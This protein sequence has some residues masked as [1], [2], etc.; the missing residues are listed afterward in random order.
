MTNVNREYRNFALEVQF[1]NDDFTEHTKASHRKWIINQVL[2]ECAHELHHLTKASKKFV[3]GSKRLEI[4]E[5]WSQSPAQYDS[6]Q[7]IIEGQ[8]VM[9]DWEHPV[10]K[11]MAD[12]VTETHGD[13]LEIG[14]GMGISATYIQERGVKSHTIVEFNND[15]IEAF[16]AWKEQYPDRDIKL[17]QG[18]WP[19]VEDQVQ[20]YDGIFFD[21]YP[22]SEEELKSLLIAS[23]IEDFYVGATHLKEGGIFTFYTGEIDSLSRFT[24]RFLLKIFSSLTISIVDSLC[25]PEDCHYYIADSMVVVKAIK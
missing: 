18:K 1:K 8:Q 7:L 10:M 9:Q 24:Q 14:F 20:M 6:S 2:N 16:K 21:T 5:E 19:D 3:A 13:I 25:P 12:I 11:A 23:C 17:I 4:K 15:V 22:T